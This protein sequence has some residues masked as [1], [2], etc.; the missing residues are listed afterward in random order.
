[1]AEP[2]DAGLSTRLLI[3]RHGQTEGNAAQIHQGR[4]DSA[5]TAEGID[6]A[7]RLATE[8]RRLYPDAAAVYASPIGRALTTASRVA[9]AFGLEPTIEADLVE[10]SFGDWEG[11]TREQLEIHGFWRKAKADPNYAAPGGESL[12][13]CGERAASAFRSIARRHGGDS[14]IVVTHQG[15]ICQGSAVLFET[16]FPGFEYGLANAGFR[17]VVVSS[18]GVTSGHEWRPSPVS[19]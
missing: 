14:V 19:L 17:E 2:G 9:A 3:A 5:L 12:R 15:P 16:P 11:S 7:A 1:M 8:L 13:Q 10:G 4:S 6:Q 18:D